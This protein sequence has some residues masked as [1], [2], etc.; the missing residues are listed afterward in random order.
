MAVEGGLCNRK[1][2]ED[3]KSLSVSFCELPSGA[4]E[5]FAFGSESEVQS[6]LH[7][8]SVSDRIGIKPTDKE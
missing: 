5:S 4:V 2:Q 1:G 8:G 7:N 3:N 6:M